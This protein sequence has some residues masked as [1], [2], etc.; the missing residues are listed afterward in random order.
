[1]RALPLSFARNESRMGFV[2]HSTVRLSSVE[3]GRENRTPFLSLE[4][5]CLTNRPD[6]LG[7][8]SGTR[9]PNPLLAGQ[10]LSH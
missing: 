3:A 6:P 1:M 2:F 8:P 4:G 9:T 10:T 7:G 5:W